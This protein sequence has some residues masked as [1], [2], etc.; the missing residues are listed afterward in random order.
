[1]MRL[2][3]ILFG[4]IVVVV[5]LATPW[6]RHNR[7]IEAL[8]LAQ[9]QWMDAALKVCE[10]PAG[11]VGR[12]ALTQDYMLKAARFNRLYLDALPALSMRDHTQAYTAAPPVE[13]A[14]QDL[15]TSGVIR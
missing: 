2:S 3:V 14:C 4:V 5:I 9:R 13:D 10:A 6:D 11:T 8:N 7:Q 1:M 12:A 15:M